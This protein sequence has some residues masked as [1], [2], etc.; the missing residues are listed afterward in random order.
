MDNNF[1]LYLSKK[2]VKC[3]DLPT[4]EIIRALEIMFKEKGEGRMEMPK[5]WNGSWDWI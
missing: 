3:L 2:D 5:K 1:L 4:S